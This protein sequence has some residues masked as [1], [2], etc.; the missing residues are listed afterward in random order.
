M[1]TQAS[2]L[3]DTLKRVQLTGHQQDGAIE[4]LKNQWRIFQLRWSA[5][6]RCSLSVAASP[7]QQ[8]GLEGRA[9]PLIASW[10]RA[11]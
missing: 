9:L 8:R 11:L 4:I 1:P 10:P 6:A 5:T 7:P 2:S 3:L